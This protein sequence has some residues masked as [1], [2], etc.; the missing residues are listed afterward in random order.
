MKIDRQTFLKSLAAMAIGL[1]F[2]AQA[3]AAE[4]GLYDAPP[5]PDAAFVRV[6]NADATNGAELTLADTV[7]SVGPASLSPYEYVLKGSYDAAAGATTLAVTLAP[8]KYYT[9]VVGAGVEPKLLEDAPLAN[10]TR[11]GL[12]FYNAT[13]KP[14]QLDAKV[15][16]KQAAIFKDVQPG[17]TAYREVSPLEVAF[18]VMDGGAAAFELPAMAMIR[19]QGTSVVALSAG[20]N[21]TAIQSLNTVNTN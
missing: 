9:I 18:I 1:L 14:L 11:A 6:L 16:G 8:Q 17:E 4:G 20:A 5:P 19:K 15:Q 2:A 10:P 12:Y 7:Y 3:N 13:G 21:V